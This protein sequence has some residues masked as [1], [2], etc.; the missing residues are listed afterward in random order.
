MVP[1]ENA[2]Y[3]E[4][5]QIKQG[6]DSYVD[7]SAQTLPAFPKSIEVQASPPATSEA[8]RDHAHKFILQQLLDCVADA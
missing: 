6:S 8:V 5:L 1:Q 3:E 4:L 7:S 2:K